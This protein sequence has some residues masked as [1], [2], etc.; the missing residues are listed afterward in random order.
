MIEGILQLE[1]VIGSLIVGLIVGFAAAVLLASWLTN[2]K[3][4]F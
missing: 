4:R 1:V 2:R 3:D